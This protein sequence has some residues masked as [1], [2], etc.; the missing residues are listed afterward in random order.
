MQSA[1]SI[2]TQG[3]L[4]FSR[5]AHP[6]RGSDWLLPIGTS[7]VCVLGSP[8]GR[9]IRELTPKKVGR[10]GIQQRSLLQDN[11]WSSFKLRY[12]QAF[13]LAIF[14]YKYKRHLKA[15]RLLISVRIELS[16]DFNRFLLCLETIRNGRNR[17]QKVE[18]KVSS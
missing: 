4:V 18:F 10:S 7:T 12:A 16:T 9:Q 14:V 11:H 15:I 8:I 2:S 1:L 3:N 6:A 13:F 5:V 17:K